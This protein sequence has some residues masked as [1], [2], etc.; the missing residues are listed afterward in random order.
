MENIV[1]R[2]PEDI[3][4]LREDL[5]IGLEQLERGEGDSWNVEEA[6]AKLLERV[7][8]SKKAATT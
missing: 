2:T 3:A 1:P 4:H 7:G 8:Q 6:K 5:A